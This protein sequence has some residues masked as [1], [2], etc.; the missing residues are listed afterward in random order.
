VPEAYY[1]DNA[2]SVKTETYA[3]LGF[4]AG[5]DVDEH[6]S[7]FLDGR[8]L[9]DR[10]YIASASVAAVATPASALFEPGTGA[11]VYGGVRLRR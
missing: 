2:N 5:W 3:L 7:L 4:R 9:L 11:A 8:N 10:K 6:V 1:V